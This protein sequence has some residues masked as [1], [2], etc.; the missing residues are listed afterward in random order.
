MT[1]HANYLHA[2]FDDNPTDVVQQITRGV[3]QKME[4]LSF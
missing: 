2:K 4:F 1:T 3:W